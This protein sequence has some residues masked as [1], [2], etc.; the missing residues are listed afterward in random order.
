MVISRKLSDD[1]LIERYIEP[2]PN[3]DHPAKWRL[4][5]RGV[6]VWAPATVS[7]SDWSNAAQM[8]EDYGV[9]LEAIEAVHACYR[10]NKAVV[11]AW[12]LTNWPNYWLGRTSMR[13]SPFQSWR[14]SGAMD[15]S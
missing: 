9:P 6:A 8:A 5:E 10:Q 3:T 13:T 7:D 11:D 1:E 4:K 14:N 12:N 2:N 15:T